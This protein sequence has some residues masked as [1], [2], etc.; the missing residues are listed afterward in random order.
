[1]K[2]LF[3][4]TLLKSSNIITGT[5]STKIFL[6]NTPKLNFSNNHEKMKVT[7]TTGHFKN[8]EYIQTLSSNKIQTMKKFEISKFDPSESS[9]KSLVTYYV[10]LNDCGPMVL[11]ALIHIKDDID[12]TLS[13]RRSC[14]EGICGSCSMNIDG[15]NSLA[16]LSYIE[17]DL[18]SSSKITPLP[19]FPVLRDLVVDMTNFYMQYKSIMPVL[20]RKTPKV[21]RILFI[22]K[23]FCY[24]IFFIL[25]CSYG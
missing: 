8:Y 17:K 5:K 14:R 2:T 24:S 13:F 9:E 7:T 6:Y 10:D 4:R 20:K 15:R 21:S 23:Y 22:M 25:A 19:F 12:S 1:M 16:C 18:S 11:D 3:N